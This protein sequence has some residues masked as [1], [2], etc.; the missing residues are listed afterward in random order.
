MRFQVGSFVLSVSASVTYINMVRVQ[1][2]LEVKVFTPCS[3][4]TCTMILEC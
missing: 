1:C 3:T 2:L 4:V